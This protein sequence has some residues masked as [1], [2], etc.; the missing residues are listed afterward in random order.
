MVFSIAKTINLS[1]IVLYQTI[2]LEVGMKTKK[3]GCEITNVKNLFSRNIEN[4]EIFHYVESVTSANSF[5]LGFLA[6]HQDMD[7]YQKHIE[8]K[9]S[10]TKSTTSKILKLMEQNGLIKRQAIDGDAR[11]K[12]IILTEKGLSINEAIHST[13][14]EVEKKAFNGFSK[15]EI[16][17][18][19]AYL[20]RIKEN[21]KNTRR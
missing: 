14:E 13:L 19:Y 15:N 10:I 20:D 6:R 16:D 3:L 9:F 17:T 12:K 18:L 7:I 8:E 21:L 11:Y 4:S 1:I 2:F 5:I